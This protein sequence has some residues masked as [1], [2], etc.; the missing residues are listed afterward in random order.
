[1]YILPVPGVSNMHVPVGNFSKIAFPNVL[2]RFQN[3]KYRKF[4]LN[5]YLYSIVQKKKLNTPKGVEFYV[6]LMQLI[7]DRYD[8]KVMRNCNFTVE[9]GQS[10][11]DIS[12]TIVIAIICNNPAHY[13]RFT[14][15]FTE[16]NLVPKSK[17]FSIIR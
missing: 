3:K 8:Y 16:S 15:I 4:L 13:V 10:C 14:Y 2:Q 6:N 17:M 12:I 9:N 1:M 5:S 7:S 11:K